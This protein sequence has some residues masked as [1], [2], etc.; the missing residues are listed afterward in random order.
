MADARIVFQHRL[1]R[2]HVRLIDLAAVESVVVD[3]HQP[4]HFDHSRPVGA[5]VD[6]QQLVLRADDRA[7]H[8]FHRKTAAALQQHRGVTGGWRRQRHQLLADALHHAQVVIFIPGAAV[9]QHRL[10]YRFRRG[11]RAGGQQQ[12]VTI[13]HVI[14]LF[15]LYQITGIVAA[16]SFPGQTTK[17]GETKNSSGYV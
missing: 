11:Q 13:G 6:D 15:G 1:H 4:R 14:H 5:V 3:I 10:F 9:E 7:Q 12:V 16:N 2:R 8:A 17:R